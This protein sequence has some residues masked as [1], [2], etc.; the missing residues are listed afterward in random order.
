MLLR[1]VHACD[2]FTAALMPTSTERGRRVVPVIHVSLDVCERRGAK[3]GGANGA[4]CVTRNRD[5]RLRSDEYCIYSTAAVDRK[6]VKGG[7]FLPFSP[8]DA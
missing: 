7:S 3:L 2:R 4:S 6:N 1:T 8:L 5:S